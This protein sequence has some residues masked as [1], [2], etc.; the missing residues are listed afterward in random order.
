[1]WNDKPN[2][3]LIPT[4]NPMGTGTNF[5]PQVWVWVRISIRSLSTDGWIIALP[6]PNPTRCHP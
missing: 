4:R 5:Y 2:G 3:Y 1:M 6:D